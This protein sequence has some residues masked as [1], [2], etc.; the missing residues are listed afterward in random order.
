V[1]TKKD[2]DAAA[3]EA[4]TS[5][6]N[7]Q[8]VTPEQ[9]EAG[10]YPKGEFNYRGLDVT[11]ENPEGSTRRGTD[12]TG[13]EWEQTLNNHYG[14]IPDTIGADGDPIDVFTSNG[15]NTYVVNQNSPETGEF[16][17][18]KVM[19][20]FNSEA[21]A[22]AAYM[23]NYEDGWKGFGSIVETPVA[24]LMRWASTGDTKSEFD[25]GD[26]TV[27]SAYTMEN[28]Q[29]RFN[30]AE[31][32]AEMWNAVP[33]EIIAAAEEARSRPQTIEI[34]TP[35][36]QQLRQDLTKKL[37]G[38]GATKQ[39][40]R[41]DVVIGAT[42]S[43]KSSAVAE[44]VAKK[45]GSII[46]DS[47]MAKEMLPEYDNGR[48]AGA[49]HQE[50][51]IINTEVMRQAIRA[52]DNIVLPIV[53]HDKAKVDSLLDLL[54]ETGYDVNVRYVDLP[55]ELSLERSIARYH[56]IGRLV[57]PDY[58]QTVGRKPAQTY[59]AL[60]NEG[61]YSSYTAYDNNVERGTEARVIEKISKVGDRLGSE[62][63]GDE[64]DAQR[65]GAA[66]QKQ[67]E[68]DLGTEEPVKQAPTK[69]AKFP[70]KVEAGLRLWDMRTVKLKPRKAKAPTSE[71]KAVNKFLKDFEKVGT[72]NPFMPSEMVIMNPEGA[73][74]E[75]G[76]AIELRE[77]FEGDIHLS[78]LRSFRRGEG[79]AE[80]AMKQVI[81]L[82]D[83]H[84]LT[85]TG[86]AKPFGKDTS[87]ESMDGSKM[88]TKRQLIAWYKRLGFKSDKAGN[89]T[90]EPQ[91]VTKWKSAKATKEK[92]VEEKPDALDTSKMKVYSTKRIVGAPADANTAE[93]FQPVMDEVYTLID[94]ELSVPKSSM[95]WYT[96]SGE[97][98]AA[99]TRVSSEMR[100]R[101]L[102]I[103]A[104]MSPD[105]S[106]QVNFN[107]AVNYAYD[108]ARNPNVVNVW[109][110]YP[111]NTEEAIKR[112]ALDLSQ[113]FD[114]SM[115][116]V[117][118]KVQ[119]FYRNL[120]D[121]AMGENVWPDDVTNDRWM[122]RVFGYKSDKLQDTQY[123]FLTDVI[124]QLTKRYNAEHKTNLKPR[125]VQAML[126][127]YKLN[128]D[129]RASN[130]DA[131]PSDYSFAES[132]SQ[133]TSTIMM[134]TI[135]S[136]E[137]APELL[138]L[139]EEESLK[140]T[141]ESLKLIRDKDGNDAILEHLDAPLYSTV[142]SEGA[143]A[144]GV[145]PN[146]VIEIVARKFRFPNGIYDKKIA[147]LYTKIS[148][149]AFSQDISG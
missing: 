147:A 24:E 51:K 75:S 109:G 88:L 58:I 9:L 129:A 52:G 10:E 134:E 65:R 133:A 63:R 108:L 132:A 103:V 96:R 87:L 142:Q 104:L 62:R 66:P 34:N 43:G 68:L 92:L 149:Y 28:G 97:M 77:G 114:K 80:Y 6:F 89:I 101:M 20:G 71:N 143:Y 125:Q 141:N 99:M 110:S 53:G 41:V 40:R 18:H 1:K 16:D 145:H 140:F 139:S 14:D 74:E 50:S 36:R 8:M 31:P 131:I 137:V 85:L 86:Y 76:A 49:V 105:T 35:E 146:S 23:D 118:N 128:E 148:Q 111:N 106:V 64:A 38:K 72:R 113:P 123:E 29:A 45:Y 135:P 55:L 116:G 107:H 70:E 69:K 117:G 4:A 27:Q 22:Q 17:E 32:S 84:G 115:W 138:D 56:E 7:D 57:D 21:D 30:Y 79:N 42:A 91:E 144:G 11:I 39:D 13:R 73:H 61:K 12:E 5:P 60:R 78:S 37:Y 136:S 122:A 119:S 93:L 59:E 82:A 102:R 127:T 112:G 120:K 47:D 33:D 98:I 44:P 124:Q 15:K 46:I 95:H 48:G 90:R 94:N 100:E 3:H 67:Q 19:H 83:K 54:S 2:M 121:E 81:D 26:G 126:W 130:P 25:L